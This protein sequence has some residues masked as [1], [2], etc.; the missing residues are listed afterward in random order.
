MSAASRRH[1]GAARVGA[2][3]RSPLHAELLPVTPRAAGPAAGPT[4]GPTAGPGFPMASA[5]AGRSARCAQRD[6][7]SAALPPRCRQ[8]GTVP[9]PPPSCRLRHAAWGRRGRPGEQDVMGKAWEKKGKEKAR[10]RGKHSPWREGGTGCR[11]RCSTQP[12]PPACGGRPALQAPSATSQ[13]GRAP[14]SPTG[15]A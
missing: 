14:A 10:C 8:E 6:A 5:R 2:P 1:K 15:T 11:P 3:Q 7:L 13:L 4:A 12:E 9:V